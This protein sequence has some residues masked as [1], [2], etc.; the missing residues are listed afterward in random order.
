VRDDNRPSVRWDVAPSP[1][2]R[3]SFVLPGRGSGS[4]VTLELE[5]ESPAD[6]SALRAHCLAYFR[7]L[8]LTPV[9]R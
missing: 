7:A 4:I 2:I 3:A 9:A 5:A 1:E 6:Q 8:G